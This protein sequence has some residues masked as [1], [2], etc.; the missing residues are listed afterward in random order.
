MPVWQKALWIFMVLAACWILEGVFSFAR[1]FQRS[2]DRRSILRHRVSNF[3]FLGFVMVINVV[4]GLATVG[5][6]S[7]CK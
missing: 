7:G 3:A 1:D 6:L 4:F 5:V 2:N